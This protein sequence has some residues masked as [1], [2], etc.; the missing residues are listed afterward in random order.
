MPVFHNDQRV[1]LQHRHVFFSEGFIEDRE[2]VEAVSGCVS[3][4]LQRVID[5]LRFSRGHALN[6]I[7]LNILDQLRRVMGNLFNVH[8][9]FGGRDDSDTAG[10]AINEH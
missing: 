7:D 1:D 5:F 10:L 8:A 2:E 6:W 4:E 3:G 9:A